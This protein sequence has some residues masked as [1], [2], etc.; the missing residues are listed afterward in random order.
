MYTCTVCT[1]NGRITVTYKDIKHG[2]LKRGSFPPN[3]K[4]GGGGGVVWVVSDKNNIIT[5]FFA[6]A[7]TRDMTVC[8]SVLMCPKIDK[9]VTVTVNV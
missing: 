6:A 9:T 3:S 4:K 2:L 5:L 7:L 1:T 8:L